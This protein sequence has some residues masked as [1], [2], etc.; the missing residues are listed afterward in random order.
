MGHSLGYP[1]RL[2]TLG[3]QADHVLPAPR[4]RQGSDSDVTHILLPVAGR[5]PLAHLETALRLPW[6]ATAIQ[7]AQ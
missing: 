3:N 2:R 6:I 4:R 7:P 5:H 1:G